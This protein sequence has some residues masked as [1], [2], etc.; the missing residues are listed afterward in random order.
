MRNQ[1]NTEERAMHI[2]Q[3]TVVLVS[4][5]TGNLGRACAQTFYDRGARTVLVDRSNDKLQEQYSDWDPGRHILAGG[6]DLTDEAATTGLVARVVERFGRLDVVANT[7]GAFRGGEPVQSEKLETWHFLMSVNLM[8]ALIIS[9]AVLPVMLQ[10]G[11]GRIV[12]VASRNALRGA[13][14]Y[15]A[16][17]AAKAAL[18]RLSESLADE[19]K[20]DG[21]NV[22]CVVPGTIDTPENRRAMPDADSSRWVSPT[23]VADVIAFLASAESHAITGATIPVFGRG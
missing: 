10:Q 18:L 5:A 6:I 17:S 19:V 16:Y 22:N 15:A 12:H 23:A 3:N 9:R 14:N 21:I 11:S 1:H 20:A 13:A 4:G 2:E 8:T 7:V